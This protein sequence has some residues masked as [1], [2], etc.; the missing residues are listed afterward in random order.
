MSE[1]ELDQELLADFVVESRE[2]LDDYSANV[3]A[4]EEEPE[5]SDKIGAVFRAAHTLKGSSA[6]FGLVHIKNFAHKLENLL[7]DV[8]QK[9]RVVTPEVIDILLTGGGHLQAMFN[10]PGDRRLRHGS[11]F[12]RRYFFK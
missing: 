2:L 4:M 6:F 3:M 5:S 12:G 7:D 8:R 11:H 1:I 10:R 9:R